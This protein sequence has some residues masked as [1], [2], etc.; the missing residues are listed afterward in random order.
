VGGEEG[1]IRLVPGPHLTDPLGMEAILMKNAQPV[2]WTKKSA[3]GSPVIEAPDAMTV[4]EFDDFRVYLEH[5]R[6]H[7][8]GM[9]KPITL[10]RWAKKLNYR[11]PRSIAMV[12]KG[13]RMPSEELVIA[14]SQDLNHSEN[15]RRYFEL[16]VRKEKYRG[17]IPG[18]IQ[19]E[20]QKLNPR[21]IKRKPL[22]AAVFSYVSS[23][24]HGAI[25]QLFQSRVCHG[26]SLEECVERIW[27]RFGKKISREDVKAA[28]GVLESLKFLERREGGLVLA[29]DSPF[30]AIDEVPSAAGRKHHNEQMDQAREALERAPM[31]EREFSCLTFRASRSKLPE[32]K[33][34]VRE[35]R[36]KFEK[37]FFDDHSS[38]VCQLN[39]QFF[40]HTTEEKKS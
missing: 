11:S 37:D 31:A 5:M 28:L 34:A 24:Y 14:F 21:L 7:Y 9:R 3:F 2:S 32:L 12:L 26:Q 16:L 38:D 18:S 36:D 6:N 10:E 25:F 40:F 4:F 29:E 35:F 8:P 23:W 30:I 22:D 15:E 33:K 17:N 13:Q 1:R 19:E 39:V 20:L 27:S